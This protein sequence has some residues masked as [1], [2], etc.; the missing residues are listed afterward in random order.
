MR[1]LTIVMNPRTITECVESFRTLGTDIAWVTGFTMEG[2]CEP[3][4]R[5]VAETD[6]D[7]YAVCADD[8]V[9]S[10]PAL[11]AV[12]AGKPLPAT[13]KPSIGCNIKWKRGN[14]PAYFA[15]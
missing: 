10:K 15:S 12:L 2:L 3:M 4:N 11:D 9:V 1:V 13:Q 8:C 6:Y 7:V 5:V 14:E